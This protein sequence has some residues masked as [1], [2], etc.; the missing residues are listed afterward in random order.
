MTR[1][2]ILD[3]IDELVIYE[4]DYDV[5]RLLDNTD[6]E[7]FVKI[8]EEVV[9]NNL[10]FSDFDRMFTDSRY[11]SIFRTEFRVRLNLEQ[12]LKES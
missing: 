10:Y 7:F 1:E 9:N 3:A 12:K 6:D 11:G 5:I 4:K 8:I 2:E